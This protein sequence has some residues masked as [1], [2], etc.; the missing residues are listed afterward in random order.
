MFLPLCDLHSLAQTSL[1]SHLPLSI[2]PTSFR[3]KTP[4]TLPAFSVVSETAATC[5]TWAC[6]MYKRI[7]RPPGAALYR[8]DAQAVVPGASL[9]N[10]AI[11]P[12]LYFAFIG[13]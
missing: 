6:V 13:L 10:A 12:F 5:C 2:F 4:L 9:L 3:Q 8:M 7:M 11:F 1:W